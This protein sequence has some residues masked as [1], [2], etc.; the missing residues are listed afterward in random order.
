MVDTEHLEKDRWLTGKEA[1]EL[2]GVSVPTLSAWRT[3]NMGP[4]YVR[5][6]VCCCR[7]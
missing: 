3:R 6:A 4:P 1:A 2:M 5:I 7:R